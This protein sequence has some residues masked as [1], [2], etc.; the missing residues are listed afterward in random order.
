M[1]LLVLEIC[2]HLGFLMRFPL[3]PEVICHSIECF[4]PKVC[5]STDRTEEMFDCFL[6]REIMPSQIRT[7]HL[8]TLLNTL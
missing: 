7:K 8:Q 2:E 4:Q 6:D 5:V 1:S 3:W